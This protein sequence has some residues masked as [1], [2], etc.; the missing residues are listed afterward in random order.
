MRGTLEEQRV[1][2]LRGEVRTCREQRMVKVEV[3]DMPAETACSA[4]G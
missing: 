3:L 2:A 4:G 1:W